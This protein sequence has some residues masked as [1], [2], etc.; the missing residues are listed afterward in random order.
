MFLIYCHVPQDS[1]YLHL[2]PSPRCS[3]DLLA[4]E[5]HFLRFFRSGGI[6]FIPSTKSGRK[7]WTS[8][9]LHTQFVNLLTEKVLLYWC[10]CQLFW[11]HGKQVHQ[12]SGSLS[13]GEI[14]WRLATL[15]SCVFLN[16]RSPI[17]TRFG[18]GVCGQIGNLSILCFRWNACIDD[19]RPCL[20]KSPWWVSR[21]PVS[22]L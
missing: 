22:P 5:T 8:Q 4:T 15:Y 6:N 3:S 9:C 11:I 1:N 7:S 20:H 17:L 16:N 12:I 10:R 18:Q 19:G 13:H 14:N 21:N 2:Q